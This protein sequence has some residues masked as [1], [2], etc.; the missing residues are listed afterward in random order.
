MDI[1]AEVLLP[2]QTAMFMM[3]F[4]SME[5]LQINS[6]FIINLQL[7]EGEDGTYKYQ[8]TNTSEEAQDI[9]KGGWLANSKAGIGK[10]IY[11]GV[12]TYYGYWADGQRNGEGV[13]TYTNQDVYSGQWK[14]GKKDGQGTYVFF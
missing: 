8:N 12:G 2:I 14:N 5:Y 9:Y 13:M 11:V 4:S 10:M 3:A 1:Q 6:L 7:R